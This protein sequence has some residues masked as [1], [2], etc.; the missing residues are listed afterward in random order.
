MSQPSATLE[1]PVLHASPDFINNPYPTFARFRNEA[2]VFWSEKGKYWIVT[3]YA[4]IQ[5]ILRDL[6]YEKG[7][8]NANT[9]NPIV[10]MLPPVKEAIKSRSTWMLNQNP[11][12]HTRLRS[13]VNRAFTPTMVNSMRGHIEDIANRL[14]D[15]VAQ[16]G[17]MDI[18]QDFAFPLPVTVI[19]EMLGV[20]PEDRHIIKGYS[21]GLT[22][23]LE[24]GFDI[25]RIT[26]A[27]KAVQEFEDYLRPLVEER[28]KNGKNDL[29]SA[30]VSAEEQGDKLSMEELLGNCVLMLVAGHETTVNLIGNSVLALLNNP[31]QMQMLKDQP[32]LCVTAVN[33]FLR[34]ESPVQTVK[35]L[36][37]QELQLHGEKIGV[38]DTLLLLLGSANRDPEHYQNADQLDITRADNKHLAF[39]TGIHHCLGSSLAEVEGQ[40]AITTLLKRFPNLKMKSQKVEFKFPFAL[41]GPKELLVTF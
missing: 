17:E 41:R 5:S 26:R 16:K 24:P 23:G 28:R 35:R 12:D 32:E 19:A 27:N 15:D 22:N 9:L 14:L 37:A 18:V 4:D 13:L 2:P 3:K 30:L 1:D 34:Y 33:E 25:G 10:K 11:P 21:Q 31:N 29:I 40:I 38:G 36:A 39:G 20:P 6:H 7:L 8:Q